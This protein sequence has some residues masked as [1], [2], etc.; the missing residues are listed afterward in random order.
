[1]QDG[2]SLREV[3]TGLQHL[4]NAGLLDW[5]GEEIVEITPAQQRG[6]TR[7]YEDE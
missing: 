7:F 4:V 2:L 3:Q 6:L 5:R 1:M